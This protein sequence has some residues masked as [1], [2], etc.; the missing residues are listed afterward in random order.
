MGQYWS[1]E[2]QY[3]SA[4]KTRVQTQVRYICYEIKF[5]GR[6]EGL[7]VSSKICDRPL[8]QIKKILWVSGHNATD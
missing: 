4:G 1:A 5:S 6:Q 2:L 7:L 3:R 8:H